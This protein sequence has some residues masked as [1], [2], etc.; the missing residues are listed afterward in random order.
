MQSEMEQSASLDQSLLQASS[1]L[2]GNERESMDTAESSDISLR[3]EN[4]Q[5][6]LSRVQKGGF[7]VK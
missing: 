1:V 5:R 4:L 7:E 6:L 3:S 2:L